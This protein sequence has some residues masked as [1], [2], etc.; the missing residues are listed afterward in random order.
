MYVAMC[1]SVE[2]LEFELYKPV[3]NKEESDGF[4]HNGRSH[5]ATAYEWPQVIVLSMCSSMP[6]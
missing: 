2:V 4:N 1:L 6:S 3:V 5:A